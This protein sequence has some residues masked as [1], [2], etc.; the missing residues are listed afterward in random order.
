MDIHVPDLI[1]LKCNYSNFAAIQVVLVAI[2]FGLKY[3]IIIEAE[4]LCWKSDNFNGRVMFYTGPFHFW[5]WKL[6]FYVFSSNHPT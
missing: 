4:E 2:Q 3:F 6:L 1:Q 5:S